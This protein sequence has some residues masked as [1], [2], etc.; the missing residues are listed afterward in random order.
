MKD[1]IKK[2]TI[3]TAFHE[4]ADA[5]DRGIVHADIFY[6][7]GDLSRVKGL[8]EQAEKYLLAALRFQSF[9][10]YV[11]YSLG[12]LHSTLHNWK[13]CAAFFSLFL[14]IL[15]TSESH[16]ELSKALKE[17]HAYTES[18]AHL[19]RAIEMDPYCP[20]YYVYR[21]ELLEEEGLNGFAQKD[22][23]EIEQNDPRFLVRYYQSCE[24]GGKKVKEFIGKVRNA[25]LSRGYD[26]LLY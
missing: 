21:A 14:N 12:L 2:G 20:I 24:T 15:E 18:L 7:F 23:A 26:S 10:P 13:K 5:I 6:F 22:Y 4:L 19:T 8:Q 1:K 16:F 17:M 25:S 9:S 11:Y 3:D